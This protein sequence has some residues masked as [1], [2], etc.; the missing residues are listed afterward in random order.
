MN[1]VTRAQRLRI[2]QKGEQIRMGEVRKQCVH[3]CAPN[4]KQAGFGKRVC[5]PVKSCHVN[6]G[7]ALLLVALY[8]PKRSYIEV[9]ISVPV[10]VTLFGNRVFLFLSSQK[11]YCILQNQIFYN[12]RNIL[13]IH[14]E[15]SQFS[16]ICFV[17]SY[18]FSA[19]SS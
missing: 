5:R 15:K 13:L 7:R 3:Q 9:L 19:T 2:V 14:Q 12:F 17:H 16:I 1:K 6:P 8:F 4:C 10:S 11:F 18:P